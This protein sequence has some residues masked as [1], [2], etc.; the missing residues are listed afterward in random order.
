MFRSL[1][2]IKIFGERFK[3]HP[4]W[5]A[6]L[7]PAFCFLSSAFLVDLLEDDFVLIFTLVVE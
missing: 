5:V 1:W 4:L 3:P 7:P 2:A 6:F